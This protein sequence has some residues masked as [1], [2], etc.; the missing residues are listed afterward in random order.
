MAKK[1]KNTLKKLIPR[2]IINFIKRKKQKR[3]QRFSH[4]VIAIIREQ[5]Q[6]HLDRLIESFL[7]SYELH[8]QKA[9]QIRGGGVNLSHINRQSHDTNQIP[10]GN[11]NPTLESKNTD[12]ES[13]TIQQ[14]SK[15]PLK[16]TNITDDFTK[17]LAD[18]NNST[19]NPIESLTIS[20]N[21]KTTSNPTQSSSPELIIS[22]TSYPKR[23]GQIHYTLYSLF[24]Q[25]LRPHRIVLWLSE[26]EFPHKE[27]DL[28]QSVLGF[29]DKGLQVAWCKENLKSYK[30]LIPSLQA[31]PNALI[32]TA[33]DDAFYPYFWLQR[34]YEAYLQAPQYIHAHRAHRICF[35]KKGAI[36]PYNAWQGEIESKQTMPSYLNFFT[37]LGGVLYPPN[38]LYKDI[39]DSSLFMRL[40][41]SNDDIWFWAMAL[42][43]GSKI[44]VVHDN[45]A[46][47]ETIDEGSQENAL[48]KINVE[49][50]QNDVQIQNVLRHYPKLREMVKFNSN[51]Y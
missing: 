13:N 47:L 45:H 1:L 27:V 21:L 35:D 17:Y 3:A 22:L 12:L 48:W 50:N 49:Q 24:T 18:S 37:G 9:S 34:L 23:M 51:E 19:H 40:A 43:Q 39:C 42:L 32:V 6:Q 20:H 10:Q 30:K 11:A 7:Y 4:K 38:S 15:A 2:F 28:P 26:E 31:F 14:D 5:N 25:S 46:N 8:T 29:Q 44:N 16:P 36:L 33:D 41:P